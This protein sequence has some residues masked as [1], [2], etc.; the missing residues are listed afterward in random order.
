MR[1]DKLIEFPNNSTDIISTVIGV[2]FCDPQ[3]IAHLAEMIGCKSITAVQKRP[4]LQ[5]QEYLNRVKKIEDDY[6]EACKLS[7]KLFSDSEKKEDNALRIIKYVVS[8]DCRYRPMRAH[9][10]VTLSKLSA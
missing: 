3:S 8:I 2:I 4:Y 10:T 7:N 5:L 9:C 1:N 6:G